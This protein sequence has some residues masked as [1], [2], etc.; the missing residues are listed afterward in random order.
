MRL[1]SCSARPATPLPAPAVSVDR[2]ARDFRDLP[3][4]DFDAA[5]LFLLQPRSYVPSVAEAAPVVLRSAGATS[6]SSSAFWACRRF[7][8][9]S[10]I[11][12]RLP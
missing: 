3:A 6:I 5:I 2:V 11:R 8:A 7:S 4:E 9:W 1:T 12:D 10:Q